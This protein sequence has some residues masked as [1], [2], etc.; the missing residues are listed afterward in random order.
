[1][2][3]ENNIKDFQE[4]GYTVLINALNED[5]LRALHEEADLLSNHLMTE[6]YDIIHDLGCIV[7]PWTC[8]YLTFEDENYKTDCEE[9]QKLRDS[10]LDWDNEGALISKLILYKYGAWASQLMATEDVYLLNE[11]YIIKPPSVFGSSQFAW[12]RDS[13]YYEDK[14][15][16]QEPTVACWTALDD[17]NKLNGTVELVDFENNSFLLEVPAGSVLFMSHRLLHHSRSNRN[18]QKFRR[19]YMAQFSRRPLVH[20]D[21]PQDMPLASRCVALAV[22]CLQ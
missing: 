5:E 8:S 1:M 15:H 11:Q 9:Y 6:G 13:D 4:K 2:L 10:I 7:E 21:K 20:Y 18:P 17:V 12:H 16:R 3:T 14:R 19:A 22:K